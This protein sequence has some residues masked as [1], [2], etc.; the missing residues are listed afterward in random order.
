MTLSTN[1]ASP[2][3]TYNFSPG[4]AAIPSPVR[5]EIVAECAPRPGRVSLLE[6]GH[7]TPEFVAMAERSEE[8]LRELLSIP[9]D[10]HILFLPGGA[11]A[12]YAMVPLNLMAF[13]EAPDYFNTGHWSERAI[14]EARRYGEVKVVA[15]A[16]G[17]PLALEPPD[18]W[19]SS[20]R[21]AYCHYVDNETLTG[22]EVPPGF[23]SMVV[24]RASGQCNIVVDATSNFLTRPMDVSRYAVIYAGA[25]KNA[26]IAGVTIVVV[27]ADLCGRAAS[28]TPSL[29]DY[30]LLAR[31][32]ACY[33][34]PPIFAW[35]VC[36]RVLEWTLAEGGA[37]VMNERCRARA[38]LVYEC[39]DRSELYVNRI[40]EVFRSRV[41]VC[42]DVRSD[43]LR[44]AFLTRARNEGLFG[45]RGHRA[46]GGIRASLYNG[47]PME[48]ARVLVE[49]MKEFERG[50]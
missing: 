38:G 23:A 25:Q 20:D 22:F 3:E 34:T 2:P 10:Y 30:A 48:G 43:R 37:A 24:G 6:R 35:W 45:L 14:T 12:Q 46:T 31:T 44:E 26:G 11:T 21:A 1:S 47:M 15:R 16:D 9:S 17:L 19:R 36:A 18:R 40:D 4:P 39:I 8:C 50:A 5:D 28:L 27:R 32:R 42:F 41:N 7:R 13:G 33:N 29:Y 49:F